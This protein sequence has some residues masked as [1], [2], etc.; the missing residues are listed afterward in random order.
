MAKRLLTIF[1]FTAFALCGRAQPYCTVHTYT[2]RDGLAANTIS[3]F[4]QTDDGLMWFSTWNGLCFFDGYRFTAF[5]N[6]PGIDETLTTNRILSCKP[7]ADGL[8]WCCTSDARAW[9]F[10]TRSSRFIDVSGIIAAKFGHTFPVRSVY[11]LDNGYT[12]IVSD[13][14]TGGYRIDDRG[15][16]SKGEGIERF[17]TRHNALRSNVINKVKMDGN[18]HEWVFTS[19]G[20]QCSDG[21][22]FMAG[23]FEFMGKQGCEQMMATADGKVVAFSESTGRSRSVAM[24]HGVTRINDMLRLTDGR[25]LLA[26]NIG[27]VALHGGRSSMLTTFAP[28]MPPMEV[29]DLFVDSHQRLWAFGQSDGVAMVNLRDGSSRWLNAKARSAVELTSSAKPFF[30]E[31]SFGTVWMVPTGGT[32]S[33][34]DEANGQLCPYVLMGGGSMGAHLPYIKKYFIDRD[35]NVWFTDTREVNLVNFRYHYFKYRAVQANEETRSVY[36]DGSGRVWAGMFNGELAVFD[37]QSNL[38]GYLN[39]SGRL[40]QQPVVFAPKIY[41][42]TGDREGR[43]WVGSKGRGVFVVSPDGKVENYTANSRDKFAL[44]HNEVYDIDIDSRGHVWVATFG[45]GVNLVGE[46]DGRRVFYHSGNAMAN[47][48][49]KG[50]GKVRRVTHTPDGVVILSTTDG[51]L[52]L[53][54]KFASPDN[55]RF[56]KTDHTRDDTAGLAGTDVMQTLVTRH[57]GVLVVTLDGGVQRIVSHNLLADNLRLQNLSEVNPAEGIA[58]SMVED[59]N[60]DVWIFREGSITRYVRRS[61]EALQYIPDNFGGSVELSESKPLCDPSTGCIVTG[62]RGGLLSFNPNDLKKSSHK[63]EIVFTGVLY[64]GEKTIVPMPGRKVLDVPSDRRNLT[65]YFSALDYSDRYLVK[66]A[67]MIEGVD[68]KWNYTGPTNSASFNSLP[69]GSHRLLVKSTNSDGVWVDN[70]TVLEINAQPT[71]WETIWAKLLY[72]ALFCGVVYVLIYINTLRSKNVMAK[73]MGE[74]KTRFFTE[75]GHKLRTPLT[76]IGGPVAEVLKGG[77]LKDSAKAHLEMVQRNASQMLELV[78]KMLRYNTDDN[79]YISDENVPDNVLPTDDSDETEPMQQG[80]KAMLDGTAPSVNS[81]RL[82]VVEDNNDLRAFLVGILSTDYTVLQAANGQE[83]LEMAEKLMPDFIVT[84]VMMPVMDGLT[85][86]RRIKQNN[87]IC[88]IPI[89]VLSAKASLEDR[90]Q[91]LKEGIDDYIT[92]PFSAI[93][94]KSRVNNIINQ[95]RM[96]Q[97]TFVE[98]IKPEDNSTFHL[99]APQIVDADNEM[100][101]QLLAYLEEHISDPTLKIEDLADAVHLG[102]SV[103]YGKIKSIVGMT[104]IDFVRHIRMRRAEE[105]VAKSNY[106]FSQIAYLV[107]FSDPKYFSKCFKKETGMTPSEYRANNLKGV[108]E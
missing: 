107:G 98:Q 23:R 81:I 3:G 79:V 103:F 30:H 31:D 9:L 8:V 37:R 101:K 25:L 42:I 104:P 95:R 86:V 88:H 21:K 19:A 10:D 91:G 78:N 56:Y 4:T 70:V 24:P 75:I 58:Q 62:V 27:V 6:T 54:D 2:V 92:K 7:G 44:S 29:T 108:L 84:D 80:D 105:L 39:R 74:M 47:Y 22:Y 73:E 28:T 35:K 40:Q 20:V 5:R 14:K 48:P 11:P 46:R 67:Y 94:L 59:K 34:Y 82:L 1:L 36:L 18:G 106:P 65:I 93:Y 51:L 16:N 45:G 60:G 102:R 76:L 15:I 71:F 50:F 96:L 41:A 26:T 97:Q 33:Y 100:M 64:Q 38:L 90:L 63:P 99:E 85:M 43:L 32:F 69:S 49:R 53:S 57:N 77:G 61:G 83:G 55:M 66:Y 52:T 13:D 87:D 89:I 68:D 72:F 17:D 12:W